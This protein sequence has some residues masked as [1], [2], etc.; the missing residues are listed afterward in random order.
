[1]RRSGWAVWMVAGV[2]VGCGPDLK[3]AQKLGFVSLEEMQTLQAAGYPTKAAYQDVVDQA[4]RRGFDS[5]DEMKSL[6]AQGYDTKA[7]W[8]ER[9][10]KLG[11]ESLEQMEALNARGYATWDDYKAVKTMTP[12]RF[13]TECKQ[14]SREAFDAR[15]K[16]QRIAWRGKIRYENSGDGVNVDI[17][18]EDGSDLKD[19]FDIDSKGL[20]PH[21]QSGDRDKFIEF[22]GKIAKQNFTTPDIEDITYAKVEADAERDARLAKARQAE[23]KL[24]RANANNAEW[25]DSKFGVAAAIECGSGTDDYLRR[26]AKYSFKWEDTGWMSTKFDRY[27]QSVPAPG[28]VRYV[29]NKLTLQNGFGAYQ[30]ITITCDY[31]TRKSAVVAY[32]LE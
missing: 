7:A 14:A 5:I 15:C 31:D 30:R 32:E 27:R 19:R 22:D 13:Y 8:N 20:L 17:K 2:L 1:M 23:D 26:V 6:Q 29:S 3:D 18:N 11:F 10:K 12:A 4:Q 24:L 21:V 9:Y 25:L 28:V 16:G